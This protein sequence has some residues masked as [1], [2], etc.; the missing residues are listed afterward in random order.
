MLN[1]NYCNLSFS[2]DEGEL[3]TRAVETI[4]RVGGSICLANRT[5]AVSNVPDVPEFQEARHIVERFLSA[6]NRDR[7]LLVFPAREEVKQNLH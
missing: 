6:G 3:V 2:L 7:S 1:D 4:V 5:D